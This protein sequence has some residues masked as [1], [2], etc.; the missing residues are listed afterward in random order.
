MRFTGGRGGAPDTPDRTIQAGRQARHAE[1]GTADHALEDPAVAVRPHHQEI[2]PALARRGEDL[3]DLVAPADL[4]V[5]VHALDGGGVAGL[6][7]EG[8][9]VRLDPLPGRLDL[10][11]RRRVPGQVLLHRDAAET[12]PQGGRERDAQLERGLGTLRAVVRHQDALEH[13]STP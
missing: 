9:E 2:E 3:A 5:E 7:G 11:E 12:A 4:R 1:R 10:A 13:R 8:T 6:L